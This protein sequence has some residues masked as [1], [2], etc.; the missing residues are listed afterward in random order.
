M[1]DALVPS[2]VGSWHLG[3][4][5]TNILERVKTAFQVSLSP[6]LWDFKLTDD[7]AFVWSTVLGCH[8]GSSINPLYHPAFNDCLLKND[9]EYKFQNDLRRCLISSM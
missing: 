4:E 5:Q 7:V 9:S 6:V 1:V 3:Q 2:S 8:L